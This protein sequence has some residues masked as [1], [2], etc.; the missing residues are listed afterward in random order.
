MKMDL[1]M[2][3]DATVFIVDDDP[4]ILRLISELV[5]SFG[6]KAQSWTS[7]EQFLS[8]FRPAGPGCL[9]LDVT[10]PGMSG[11]KLQKALSTAGFTLPVIMVTAHGDVRMAVDAMRAGARNFLEKPLRIHELW[12]SIQ[13]ALRLDEKM[14]LERRRQEANSRKIASLTAA[15]R[16][17]FD[18]LA[19]GKTNKMIAE[20]LGLSVRTVEERR[21]KLIKK[22][23]VETRAALVELAASLAEPHPGQLAPSC[24][25]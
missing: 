11:L 25:G 2:H 8:E 20:E 19:A 15:E 14:W 23:G 22:L 13:E 10:M 12:E 4:A 5:A 16:Q 3:S 6:M 1:D 24:H 21:A 9:V 17:V 18:L 7:A